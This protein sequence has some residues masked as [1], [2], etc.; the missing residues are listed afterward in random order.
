MEVKMAQLMVW[1]DINKPND[2]Q[3]IEDLFDWHTE[4]DRMYGDIYD[5][6]RQS[7]DLEKITKVNSFII[8]GQL[9]VKTIAWNK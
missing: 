2:K 3:L 5:I 6:W 7:T 1:I 8:A 4:L 9:K